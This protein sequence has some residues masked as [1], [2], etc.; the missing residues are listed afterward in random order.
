MKVTVIGLGYIGLPTAI[1]LAK[2]GINVLGVDINEEYLFKINKNKFTSKEK[3]LNEFL[4]EVIDNG[5]LK[6]HNTLEKSDVYVIVVPTPIEKKNEPDVSFV[7]DV[8]INLAPKL[9]I[10]NL[11]LIESTCPV[12]TTKKF[13]D[14]LFQKRPDLKDKFYM[15]YCPERVIPGD[16]FNELLQNDRIVG[17]INKKSSKQAEIFYKSFVKGNIHLTDSNT[18]EL[19]KLAENASRDA[20]IAFANELSIIC[21]KVDVNPWELVN[22]ANKHPRVNILNPGVGVGGHCIAV[23]PWFL[24]SE[25]KKESNLIATV[26]KTNLNK[27]EWCL[28]KSLEAIASFNIE[29]KRLPI[30]ACMGLSYKPDVDDLRESPAFYI[31]NNIYNDYKENTLIIEPNISEHQLFE[32]ST[33][34]DAL[35]KADIIVW[36]VLH[37]EFK[38]LKI[39]KNIIQL[40]F[41][42]LNSKHN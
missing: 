18:A 8:I 1:L 28:N 11:V 36:L 39:N 23:D 32:L 27:T 12:G 26:R 16:I 7:N 19:C 40:D 33:I 37:N 21:E 9:E 41:I 25:F 3:N 31:A 4:K 34:N 15:A 2:S 35:E 5:T 20:Q 30:I 42:G 22:L 14:L 10:G 17:G 29:N 6:T 38:S 24:V 13:S